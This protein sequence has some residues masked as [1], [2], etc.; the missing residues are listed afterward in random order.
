M[1]KSIT[2][3]FAAPVASKPARRTRLSVERLEDRTVPTAW[4]AATVAELVQHMNDANASP[5]PDTITLAAGATF[6]LTAVNNTTNGNNGLPVITDGDGLTIVGNGRVIERSAV[7]GTPAF[8]LLEVA[9]G[10]SLR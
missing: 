6:T 10:A 9:V 1:F 3:M 5:G 2:R 8:R 7:T 4:T